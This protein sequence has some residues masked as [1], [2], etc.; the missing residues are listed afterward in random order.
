MTTNLEELIFSK[1]TQNQSYTATNFG[2]IIRSNFSSF[3]LRKIAPNH[4]GR[5]AISTKE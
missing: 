3:A 4:A 1:A 2:E 5:S